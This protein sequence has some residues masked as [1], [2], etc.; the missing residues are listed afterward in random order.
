[1]TIEERVRSLYLSSSRGVFLFLF[2]RSI[3][4]VEGGS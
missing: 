2:V 3:S 4:L 1:M